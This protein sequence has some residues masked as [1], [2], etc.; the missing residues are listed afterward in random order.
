MI[1]Y[2]TLAL[3]LALLASGAAWADEPKVPKEL[4]D[5]WCADRVR[6]GGLKEGNCYRFG[7]DY[8]VV[9]GSRANAVMVSKEK[10]NTFRIFYR[11]ADVHY[12]F[13]IVKHKDYILAYDRDGAHWSEAVRYNRGNPY[14]EY[15][16]D[17]K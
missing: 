12:E 5:I 10:R 4:Q 17:K 13:L 16:D 2:S 3:P 6:I 9:E 1:K 14:A 11:F 15:Y 8:I 7:P